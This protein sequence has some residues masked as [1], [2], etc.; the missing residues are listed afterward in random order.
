MKNTKDKQN[1]EEE[2]TVRIFKK[3]HQANKNKEN[4]LFHTTI[5]F[6]K[7]QIGGVN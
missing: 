1:I 5:N 7:N 2:N 6:I 3:G 4:N